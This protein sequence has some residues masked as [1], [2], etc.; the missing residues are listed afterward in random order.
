MSIFFSG[1]ELV[2]IAIGIEENGLAFYESAANKT[3]NP[4]AKVIYN[5]LA[6]EEKKHLITFQN[7]QKT[8][9]QYQP[10]ESYSGEYMHYL[11][12]LVD[13]HVFSNTKEAQEKADMAPNEIN[14]LNIGIQ[15]E[16]DSIFFYSEMQ[17]LVRKPDRQIV[18]KVMDEEKA[19]LRQLSDLK[20]TIMKQR[21]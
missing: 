19:H 2:E 14:A 3:Q 4:E 11:K 16:K 10:P 12:A 20:A 8:I 17:K 9:G 21:R 5:Y 1:N 15:A 6:G 18:S 7:M 13:S